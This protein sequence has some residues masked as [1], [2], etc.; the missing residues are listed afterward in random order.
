LFNDTP[1]IEPLWPY[2]PSSVRTI[3]VLHDIAYG[4]RR[5]FID[6]KSSLNGVA[7]VSQYVMAALEKDYRDYSGA[8]RTIDNGTEYPASIDRSTGDGLLRLI[9]FGA[10]DRQ[11]G[12]YDLP[13]VLSDCARAG[14]ECTLTIIGGHDVELKA[15]LAS[16]AGKCKVEWLGRLARQE[17]FA[18]LAEA[19]VFLSL[20]RG[21]SFGLTTVEAMAMGLCTGRV[22][23]WWHQGYRCEWC[24]WSAGSDLRL[25]RIGQGSGQVRQGS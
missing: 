7:T 23:G 21:E 18:K 2:I 13:R 1:A 14:I 11:K 5:P 9:F 6:Y 12:A 16:V 8:L 15:Q 17:C 25:C 20:S 24:L 22:C 10:I 4:W 19:D 3:G